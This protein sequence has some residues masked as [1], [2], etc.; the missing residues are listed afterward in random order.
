MDI[1]K[2]LDQIPD[3]QSFLTVDEM[4]RNTLA[5]AEQYPDIVQV[6]EIGRSRWDHPIYCLV[7]G[8]GSQ[9]ALLYGCPHPN[10][11]I[12]AMMLEFFT[13]ALCRNPELREELDYTFYIVKSS[14]P[15]GTKLNEGW[16][17]GP[18]TVSHYQR[19]FFR[20]A[21]AQQVE[22]SF[23]IDYKTHHFHQPI[24]E[25]RAL[26]EIIDT[27]K[28]TFIYSLHNAGFGGCYWYVTEGNEALFQKL[29]E[30]PA[31]E[32]VPLSLGEP[33][34]PYCQE[35]Y[36]GVYKMVGVIAHYD[37]LEKFMPGVDPSTLL[38][39]GTSSDEYA[40]RDGRIQ[41]RALINEMP[42]FYDPRIEDTRPSD[43]TRRDAI[44]AECDQTEAD[45]KVLTPIYE[46]IKPLIHTWNPFFISIQDRMATNNAANL[47][48]K[49]QW[50]MNPDFEQPAT[51]A[52]KFENLYGMGFYRNLNFAVL[53]RACVYELE[54]NRDLTP[55]DAQTLRRCEAEAGARMEE[56]LR[57]LEENLHYQAIPIR[58]LV[59]IQMASG[60]LYAQYAHARHEQEAAAR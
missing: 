42:Y 32:Q 9:N 45:F 18:F 24:P 43:M 31:R 44:L 40:N 51:E 34:M 37:Y 58:K 12:G 53:R 25:T 8:N 55:A 11:P 2:I 26:M 60:L 48:A 23:P 14:D 59:R 19:N 7:I 20:P 36:P 56:N 28:P 29:Y 49:R 3:Y 50:A 30:A 4:D 41:A 1:L 10:E 21:Y 33:E 22:W 17:K 15:D 13:Q 39:S 35:L 47:E 46:T 52:Q 5:L 38:T 57:Y 27:R 6:K 54:N 16:F